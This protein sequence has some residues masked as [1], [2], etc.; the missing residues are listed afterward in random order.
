[1]KSKPLIAFALTLTL[2]VGCEV[3][4][5]DVPQTKVAPKTNP[6]TETEQPAADE[7]PVAT[8]SEPREFT[9]QDGKKGKRSRKAGGYLGAVGSARFTSVN[10]MTINQY[11]HALNL[12]WGTNGY[13]P[14]T[15]DEFM[16]KI[17]KFNQIQL[18]ELDEG[19]EYIYDPEDHT[20]KIQSIQEQPPASPKG[21]TPTD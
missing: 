7:T 16:E 12:Y 11:K 18:P 9:P 20:L 4:E 6:K 2:A 13:Y 5:L 8:I 3:S 21:E 14:K 1:M 10:S 17:I 15:H 19:V